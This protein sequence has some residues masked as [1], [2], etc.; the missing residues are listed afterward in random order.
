MAFQVFPFQKHNVNLFKLTNQVSD[1]QN[2]ITHIQVVK[3][4]VRKFKPNKYKRK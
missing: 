1:I 3:I 4:Q 2:M